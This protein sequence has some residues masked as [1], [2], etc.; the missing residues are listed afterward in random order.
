MET[1]KTFQMPPTIL[2]QQNS[3]AQIGEKAELLGKKALI[4]SDQ[5]M[6]KLGYVEDC[7][8]K[9]SDHSVKSVVFL[10]VA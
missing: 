8:Q 6:Q 5:I 1:C 7:Q 4:I 2:Y 10:G 3:F 9:L